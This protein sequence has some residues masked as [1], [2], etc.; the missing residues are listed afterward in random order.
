MG[1]NSSAWVL[2]SHFQVSVLKSCINSRHER[3]WYF[4]YFHVFSFPAWFKNT[5]TIEVLCIDFFFLEWKLFSHWSNFCTFP[6]T[7]PIIL[8]WGGYFIMQWKDDN[9]NIPAYNDLFLILKHIAWIWMWGVFCELYFI[10]RTKLVVFSD[11]LLDGRYSKK[12]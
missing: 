1:G 10:S 8:F 5:K 4:M 7:C 3:S 6:K 12:V 9:D 2:H 11:W